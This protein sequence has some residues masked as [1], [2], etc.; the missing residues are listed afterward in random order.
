MNVSL[1]KT[2]ADVGRGLKVQG[3]SNV[4]LSSWYYRCGM[5]EICSFLLIK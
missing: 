3:G 5:S 1:K 2:D 4:Q